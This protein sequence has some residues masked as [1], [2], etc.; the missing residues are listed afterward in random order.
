M[1]ERLRKNNSKLNIIMQTWRKDKKKVY[2]QFKTI[3]IIVN[4]IL[5]LSDMIQIKAE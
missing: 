2:H 1:R 4:Q 3:V 5:K